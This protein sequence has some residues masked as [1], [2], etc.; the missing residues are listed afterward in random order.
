MNSTFKTNA[1]RGFKWS[2]LNKIVTHLLSF[3]F[4]V[5]L[6]RLLSPD[7]FGMFAMI[8]VF[9]NFGLLFKD[10]GFGHA[11]I[12][13]KD[14]SKP[15]FDSVFVLN[16]LTGVTLTTLFFLL[17]PI[18]AN[19]Y[20]EPQLTNLTK[21]FSVVF[22]I[23]SFG[24]VNL[25]ELKKSIDFKSLAVIENTSLLI[26]SLIAIG[27]AFYGFAVW[28]LIARTIMNMTFRTII[29]FFVSN[30][31]PAFN[32]NIKVIKNLW[33]YSIDVSANG[34]LTY[35]M[36]NLDNLMIGKMLGQQS[37]GI[38]N[39]AYQIMLFPISSISNVIKDVLF[40]SF[41]SIKNDIN[42]IRSVYLKVIQTI[43]LITFPILAGIAILSEP[44]V[45]IVLGEQWSSMISI[46]PLLALVA[47]PQSIL[48]V[49]G[50][51]YLNTGRPDIPLKINVISL[52]V[53]AIGFYLG[54]KLNGVIGLVY[55]YIIIYVT[56]IIPIYYFSAKN[57]QLNLSDFI[58]NLIPVIFATFLMG[59][60]LMLTKTFLLSQ[61]N[62]LNFILLILTG[63][64]I[65]ILIIFTLR[66]NLSIN[67]IISER[68]N[69]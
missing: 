64:F 26:S 8:I 37:L 10:F 23:Q 17:A 22:F 41:S 28:S 45:L 31:R 60:T 5:I 55:A 61:T 53:F 66:K 29:V 65:Y 47:I 12:Y 16:V 11:L 6:A 25:I 35:W 67:K 1:L 32:L 9:L 50:T 33:R 24:L 59:C 36:R 15:E 4:S 13:Q 46:L 56:L 40:P 58:K 49:N 63:I 52:P 54:L 42:I 57:I 38:Y 62:L 18:I 21:V 3:I 68:F 19:F 39:I 7:D 2:F 51:L 30:Y 43:A 14:V 20:D 44:F 34:F 69:K 48:T 27:L